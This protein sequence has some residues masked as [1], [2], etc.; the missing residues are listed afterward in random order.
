MS[1]DS[2]YVYAGVQD[3][4]TVVA[5]SVAAR[6]IVRSFRTPEGAGPDPVLALEK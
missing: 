1:P 6:K 4:D 5:V 3:K 2:R